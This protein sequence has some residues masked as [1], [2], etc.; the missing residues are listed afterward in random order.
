MWK[1]QRNFVD[2]F[3]LEIIICFVLV[4]YIAYLMC[5]S[6][7]QWNR[8]EGQRSSYE[9]S[10]EPPQV[11]QELC[12]LVQHEAGTNTQHSTLRSFNQLLTFPVTI[13]SWAEDHWGKLT[14]AFEL[15]LNACATLPI[16][17][18]LNLQNTII[19]MLQQSLIILTLSYT[20]T[21]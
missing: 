15:L 7:L 13:E 19:Q 2:T 14:R 18:A 1:L 12:Q 10:G 3:H 16:I 21:H 17:L 5:I 11:S 9:E 20:E 4:Q 8:E 6:I